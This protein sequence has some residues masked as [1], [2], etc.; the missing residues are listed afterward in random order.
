MKIQVV[1]VF[2]FTNLDGYGDVHWPRDFCTRPMIGDS[3]EGRR[4]SLGAVGSRPKLVVIQVTHRIDSS[5]HPLLEV[6][7]HK[8]VPR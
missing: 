3:V 4:S 5:G 2:C 6:E 1:P 7:L 8:G